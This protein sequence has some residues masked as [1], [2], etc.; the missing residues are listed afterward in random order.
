MVFGLLGIL[1]A[2]EEEEGCIKF[3][4]LWDSISVY[5]HLRTFVVFYQECLKYQVFLIVYLECAFNV[6]YS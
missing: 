1:I 5:I 6:K 2:L 4:G 3:R